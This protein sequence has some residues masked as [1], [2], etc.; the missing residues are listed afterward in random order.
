MLSMSKK[1]K[2]K[3]QNKFIIIKDKINRH[4]NI[5]RDKFQTKQTL[6]V[7]QELEKTNLENEIQKNTD[8][9]NEMIREPK[10]QLGA[11]QEDP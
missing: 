3:W 4:K 2:E 1:S 6:T 8:L 11:I 5:I 9:V 7:E 10:K